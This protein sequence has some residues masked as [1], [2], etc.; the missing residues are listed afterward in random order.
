MSVAPDGV[1]IAQ[2]RLPAADLPGL[3]RFY[4]ETLGL[5]LASAT[6]GS[7]S[8]RV[9]ASRLTFEQGPASHPYHFAFGLPAARFRAAKTWLASRRALILDR[10]GRDEFEF[11]DWNARS[12]YFYDPAGNIVE[13]I[14]RPGDLAADGEPFTP[15]DLTGVCEAGLAVPDVPAAVSR[16]TGELGLR[17]YGGTGSETFMA[18]GDESGQL[19]VVRRGREWYP[20]T[21]V[22][23][24]IQPISVG[25]RGGA[26]IGQTHSGLTITTGSD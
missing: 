3:R 22:A 11:P 16:L 5:Q 12:V 4:A 2:L 18:V 20:D 25:L 1:L 6:L 26:L 8:L 21:G 10:A 13:F 23:A 7:V 9:G 19:I 17:A 14:A 24:A 15:S